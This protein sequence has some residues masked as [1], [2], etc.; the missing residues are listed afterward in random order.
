MP[1]NQKAAESVSWLELAASLD[2]KLDLKTDLAVV[3][4][5]EMELACQMV[6]AKRSSC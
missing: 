3:A 5:L 2:A 4:W 1:S 6:L